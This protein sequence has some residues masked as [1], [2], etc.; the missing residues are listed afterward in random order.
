[1][2]EKMKWVSGERPMKD[3]TTR[4]GRLRHHQGIITTTTTTNDQNQSCFEKD[5][6]YGGLSWPQRNYRCSFCKKEFKS[7]QALGGHMNVHRRD[8]ARLRQLSPPLVINPNPS[9]SH[10]SSSA[11]PPTP[12]H[13]HQHEFLLLPNMPSSSSATN[14]YYSPYTK[15]NTVVCR[16]DHGR[17]N[18]NKGAAVLEFMNKVEDAR[19]SDNRNDFVRLDLKLGLFDQDNLNH[20]D[21]D[22]D[23]E[24]RLGSS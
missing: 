9:F 15:S 23:L 12:H 17:E 19:V 16:G 13:Q 18:K 14:S 1:M 2:M 7:A 8:R 21:L 4:D 5:L 3:P 6:M 11:P 20:Q 24:L 22:L 10:L